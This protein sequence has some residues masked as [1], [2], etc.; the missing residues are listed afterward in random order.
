MVFHFAQ[1]QSGLNIVTRDF[2]RLK[3]PFWI[4]I[5]EF[6]PDNLSSKR[7]KGPRW[8]KTSLGNTGCHLLRE[9]AEFNMI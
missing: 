8:G 6:L 4:Q 7:S 9:A 5:T 1:L 3:P 2:F